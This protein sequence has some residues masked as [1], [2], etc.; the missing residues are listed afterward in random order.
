MRAVALCV[1]AVLVALS[2]GIAAAAPPPGF[3]PRFDVWRTAAPAAS[4]RPGDRVETGLQGEVT[5]EDRASERSAQGYVC[6]IDLVGQYQ[7]KGANFISASYKNCTY[8]GA[9]WPRTDGVA[10][11]DASDPSHPQLTDNLTEP[12]MVGGTWESLKVN[13]TRGL[14]AATGVPFY[15]GFGYFSI[16]DISRIAPILGC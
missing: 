4:C 11:V 2:G 12:A 14:L 5:L 1:V 9:T 16:Y 6:N 3:D 7:G 8:V 10:V 13:E 15:T